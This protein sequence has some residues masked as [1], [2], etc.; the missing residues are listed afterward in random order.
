[1]SDVSTNALMLVAGAVVGPTTYRSGAT[2]LHA[3]QTRLDVDTPGTAQTT[4]R[5]GAPDLRAA[6]TPL[7]VDT[8]GAAQRLG[9]SPRT[10]VD[11]RSRGGGPKWVRIARAVRYRIDWLDQWAE[12][13]AVTSTSQETAQA[14]R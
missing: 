9:V 5:G 3:G 12:D 8:P 7:Y 11:Y 13:K 14:R 4:H 2:D 1:M 10:L 6:R